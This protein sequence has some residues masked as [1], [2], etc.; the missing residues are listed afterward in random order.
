MREMTIVP[1]LSIQK[2]WPL[3]IVKSRVFAFNSLLN[4]SLLFVRCL[5]AHESRYQVLFEAC[6][7]CNSLAILILPSQNGLRLELLSLAIVM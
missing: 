7:Y 6:I 5:K 4:N 1:T 2:I 3:A